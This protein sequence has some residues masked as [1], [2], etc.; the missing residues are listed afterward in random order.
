VSLVRAS[1]TA[2]PHA[3]TLIMAQPLTD[4]LSPLGDE[5]FVAVFFPAAVL[6]AALLTWPLAWLLPAFAPLPPLVTASG[7]ARCL[8]EPC[9]LCDVQVRGV[10]IVRSKQK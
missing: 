2:T 7:A 9:L 5:A 10:R 3:H 8:P 4:S 1:R 6:F